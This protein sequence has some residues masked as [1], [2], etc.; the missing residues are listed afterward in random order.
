MKT[1]KDRVAVVTGAAGGI[2]RA[3]SIELAKNGCAVAISDVNEAGLAETAAAITA[4]GARVC[5]H[6][7]NVADKNRMERY[8][9]EVVA[10]LGAVHIL[11]NNAGVSVGGT[12][13]EQTLDDW[14]WLMGINFWGVIYGCKFFL[15]YLKRSEEG[16]IVNMSSMFGLMG[17][18]LQG[19]YCTSKFAIRGFSEALWTELKQDNIG[20]TVVHPCG[21]RTDIAKSMRFRNQE[22]IADGMKM[23][24]TSPILPEHVA[25]AI[26]QAIVKN[27]MRVLIGQTT[28]FIDFFKRLHPALP[29]IIAQKGF[30]KEGIKGVK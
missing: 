15:P 4:L 18:P 9:D 1:L 13:E 23:I 20:V 24:D 14:E 5:S 17:A 26:I 19:S 3:T 22:M 12:F 27:K 28:F 8:A 30:Q 2:G 16:H 25:T 7:V 6:T 29:Q 11:V 21:V 10:E